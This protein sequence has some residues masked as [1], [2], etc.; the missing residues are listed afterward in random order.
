MP[1]TTATW[2]SVKT[3]AVTLLFTNPL[4]GQ[5]GQ[6]ATTKLTQTISNLIGP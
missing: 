2:G 6:P 1:A 3:V 5:S 4:F